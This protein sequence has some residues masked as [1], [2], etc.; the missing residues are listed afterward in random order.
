MSN[1]D[2]IAEARRL[3]QKDWC[4]SVPDQAKAVLNALADALEAQPAPLVADPEALG[5]EIARWLPT[6]SADADDW[7]KIR[8]AEI[9]EAL[10][11]YGV[12]SVAG[13][14]DRAVAERAWDEGMK[15]AL[16]EDGGDVGPV[17]PYRESEGK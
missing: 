2:L 8:G 6:V 10:L 17:N 12:V 9:A 13:D 15:A 11:T 16:L 4:L 5:R 7:A 3:G 14:R 1:A